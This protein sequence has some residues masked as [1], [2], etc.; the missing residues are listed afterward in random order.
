MMNKNAGALLL[1]LAAINGLES[2]YAFQVYRRS[3]TPSN[4][5]GQTDPFREIDIDLDIAKDCATNFGKYSFEEI[6]QCRE[7]E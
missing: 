7:G 4:F 3:A 5:F 6:E 1:A 2:S